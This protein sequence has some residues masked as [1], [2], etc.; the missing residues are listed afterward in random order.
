MYLC[1]NVLGSQE[2]EIT[3]ACLNFNGALNLVNTAKV[4]SQAD[5][6]HQKYRE[7]SGKCF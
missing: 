2:V 3:Q 4:R 1:F 6:V 5:V 7:P